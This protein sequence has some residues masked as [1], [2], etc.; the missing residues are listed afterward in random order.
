M[1][2]AKVMDKMKFP[3]EH[4]PDSDGISSADDQRII[5]P[6]KFI[7]A[8][9]ADGFEKKE[10]S[11]SAMSQVPTDLSIQVQEIT[12]YVHKYPLISKCGY[13]SR[14][15]LQPKKSDSCCD[16][17]LD[18][19]PGGS[20][21]FEII[22]KF[23]YGLPISLNVS[24]VAA[25]RCASEFL[26][27]TE[28][29]DDGNLISKSEAFFTFVV[30]SS[31]RDSITVLKS[32]ETLSPW[33]ENLQIVRRCCDTIAWKICRE[34]STIGGIVN[35]DKWWFN[36]VCTLRIDYFS[37]IISVLKAKGMKPEI[38]ASCIIKYEEN[39][40][41]S[42]ESERGG[43]ASISYGRREM[44]WKIISGRKQEEDI[45]P[46]KE[47]RMIVESLVSLLPPE[48]EAIPCKFLLKMLKMALLYSASP[49]IVS[50]LE[51]RAG[52]V[53]ESADVNDLLIPSHAVGDQGKL[54]NSTEEQTMHN[55]DIVQRMLEYFLL[56]DQQQQ[57]QQQQP[58]P[59]AISKLLDSYLAEIA[60]DPKLPVTKFLFL[61]QSLP[62]NAR[63]SDDGLYRAIDTF[64]K[65]HP[66]LSDH[67]RRRLCKIMN[68][69]KL[70]LDACA[71]AAQNDRLP[72]RIMIQVLF[73][74]QMKIKAAIQGNVQT[75]TADK[76]DQESSRSSTNK[77][78]KAL[79]IELEK[80]KVQMAELQ[81]D[82]S[83]LQQE[84]QKQKVSQRNS[85]GWTVGWRKIRKSALFNFKVDGEETDESHNRPIQSRRRSFPR[86]QSVS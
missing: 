64:L 50:E 55:I 76:S 43:T 57:Q 26:E 73:S 12:F 71:H 40:L 27:M 37:R 74:E 81:R 63:T 48:K 9:A 2:E 70:S 65:T 10:H 86:R 67:E 51:K 33:T 11:W 8:A 7:G 82:H 5:V 17:K 59:L 35:G 1:Q 49:A 46:T 62:E 53:L 31:W 38:T 54:V 52:L 44:Q 83:E 14:I 18:N 77:E 60:R 69:G 28:E 6:S 19:F 20:E 58:G 32:C 56:Y 80:V 84:Y 13:F 72:L 36:D 30:L 24:N 4:E 47:H 29:L 45:G 25:L 75:E 61:A 15:E 23:C 3:V 39:W 79:K 68:C 78:V 42:M 85:S 16:L 22:L 34:T 41:P 66:S 21:I